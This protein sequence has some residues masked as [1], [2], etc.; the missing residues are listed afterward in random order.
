[1]AAEQNNSDAQIMLGLM[2]YEGKG[3][4]KD[5]VQAHKWL[6]ISVANGAEQMRKSL[7]LIEKEMTST[8]IAEAQ[9]LARMWFEKQSNQ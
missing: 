2:Y 7:G 6:N 3:V 4:I 9:K 5:N 1:M 8:Q